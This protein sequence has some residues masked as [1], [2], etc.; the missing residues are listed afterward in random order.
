VCAV[1]CGLVMHSHYKS[2]DPWTAGFISAPDQVQIPIITIRS[3][4]GPRHSTSRDSSNFVGCF[5]SF[6][7][8]G[9][10]VVAKSGL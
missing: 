10:K 7:R 9:T 2:C 1:F 5:M 4:F 3:F 6:Q 8:S